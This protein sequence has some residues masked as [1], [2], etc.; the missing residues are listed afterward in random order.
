LTGGGAERSREDGGS[1]GE[2]AWTV[3]RH[4]AIFFSY[5]NM[6]NFGTIA[7]TRIDTMFDANRCNMCGA[8]VFHLKFVVSNARVVITSIIHFF[9]RSTIHVAMASLA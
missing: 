2:E 9:K 6:A 7:W 5:C 1:Q 3:G 8:K 4:Y